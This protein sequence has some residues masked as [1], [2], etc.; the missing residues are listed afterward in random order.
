M[1][2]LAPSG[3]P[4]RLSVFVLQ[5]RQDG[6]G[7]FLRDIALAVLTSG[8]GAFCRLETDATVRAITKWLGLAGAATA[9]DKIGLAA[10]IVLVAA[11]IH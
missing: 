11:G 2:G 9:E 6:A 7:L 1:P 4:A 5:K 8:Y 3:T 10:Q